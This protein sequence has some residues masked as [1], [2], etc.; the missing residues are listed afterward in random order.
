MTKCI[1]FT[2]RASAPDRMPFNGEPSA[3]TKRNGVVRRPVDTGVPYRG[4]T[5][6][7]VALPPLILTVTSAL[8]LG[9]QAPSF[10]P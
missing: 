1:Q 4:V 2:L 6:V 10:D 9:Q 3:P 8:R 5:L 7:T